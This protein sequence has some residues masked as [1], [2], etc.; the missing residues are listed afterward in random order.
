MA[1]NETNLGNPTNLGELV[2]SKDSGSPPALGGD[3]VATNGFCGAETRVSTNIC[4][5]LHPAAC[6][7]P[8]GNIG[9]AWHDT[10]DGNFEIYFRAM[11]GNLDDQRLSLAQGFAFDPTTG[12]PVSLSCTALSQP[13]G[14]TTASNILVTQGGGRL[15]VNTI[16]RVAV[17]TASNGSI[18]FQSIGVTP[19]SSVQF[20]NG[21]NVGKT[22]YVSRLLAPTVAE[23]NYVDGAKADSDFVYSISKAEAKLSTK[24]ARLTC[25]RGNSQ[26]PDI[27]AD[28]QGRFHIVYQDSANGNYELYYIQVY[29]QEIGK[30]NCVG[31]SAPV[32]VVGF[33]EV[34]PGDPNSVTVY[35][36]S[37]VATT[38][39][40]VAPTKV[41]YSKTGDTGTLFTFGNKLLSDAVPISEGPVEN[42]T[43]FHKIFRDFY[44][45]HGEW[46]GISLAEDRAVWDLQAENAAITTVPDFIGQTGHPIAGVDD[47]GTRLSIENLAFI[48]QSPP[49]KDVEITRIG[50]PLKPRCL[51]DSA[52]NAKTPNTASLISAPK[53]PVPPGYSDA[54]SLAEILTSPLAQIDDSVPPRF[55]VEGDT[56]GTVFTN[57]L[58]DDGRGQFSRFVFNCDERHQ[59]KEPRFIL[60]QR[61]CGSELCA[62]DPTNTSEITDTSKTAEYKIKLQ[63]WEGPDYRITPDQILS[64]QFANATKLIEKEFGFE[65]GEDITSFDF[66]AGELKAIDGR[67]LFF[68]P[69]PADGAEF[70]VE[71]VGGGHAVWSTD[72]L[73]TFDQYY[74]PFTVKPNA[75]L[76]APVYYEGILKDA[77]S[78]ATSSA[79]SK[80]GAGGLADGS[81]FAIDVFTNNFNS[82]WNGFI[83]FGAHE[84]GVNGA[85][86]DRFDIAS[87][88]KIE[89]AMTA[90]TLRVP[91]AI[92]NTFANQ[93]TVNQEVVNIKITGVTADG[94]PD[95][96][97]VLFSSVFP[98]TVLPQ[99]PPQPDDLQFG[100]ELLIDIPINTALPV[101]TY[102]I[103]IQ[104]RNNSSVVVNNSSIVDYRTS[105]AQ[106]ENVSPTN[107][108]MTAY[109]VSG[110]RKNL[111]ANVWSSYS[112]FTFILT[113]EGKA[114]SAATTNSNGDTQV[115]PTGTSLVPT[116]L[117]TATVLANTVALKFPNKTALP[118][119]STDSIG[120]NFHIFQSNNNAQKQIGVCIGSGADLNFN[121]N[122]LA[123]GV[124]SFQVIRNRVTTVLSTGTT[125]EVPEAASTIQSVVISTSS[126]STG[127]STTTTG[128]PGDLISTPPIRLTKS[129]GDSV[130]PRLAIDS[131]D[132]IWMVY[133][134][135]RTGQNEV[136]LGRYFCGKWATSAN[137]G[138][139]VRLTNASDNGKSA[140]FPNIALDELGN[141]H[142]VY[143]SDDTTDEVSEIFYTRSTGG[144]VSFVTPKQLTASPGQA[145]MPDICISD[146]ATSS[147]DS[148]GQGTGRTTV[149]WHDNRFGSYEIMAAVKT[150]GEWE[151]SGQGG[152]DTRI[153]Q[154]RGD[155][156]FPRA[157]SDH[158]GNVRVVYHDRRRGIDN[159]CVYMSTFIAKEN[160][161]DSTA[162]GGIDLLVSVGNVSDESLHP[163]VAIDLVDGVYVAWHDTR[164][165]TEQD[166]KEEVMGAYCARSNAPLGFCGP[167]LT[168][169]EAFVQTSFDIVDPVNGFPIT[170]T[171]IP[172]VGLQIT[173]PGATFYRISNE[174]QP[175]SEWTTFKPTT[176]L[177][178]S[179]IPWDLGSGSGKK[180]ICIQVQDATT[181]GF[182]ICKEIVLQASLPSFKVE[183]FKDKEFM[184]PLET[185]NNKPVSPSGDIYVRLTSST[186]LIRPPTFDIISKGT[187]M[188]FNQETR[189]VSGF[190]GFSGGIGPAVIGDIVA[191]TTAFSAFGGT[192]FEGRF[193]VHRD[194]GLYYLDGPARLIPHGKDIRGQVF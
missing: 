153:T 9:V 172:Q 72:G 54:V 164:F 76:D 20:I 115:V 78:G 116:F 130:H 119:N 105:I 60:G 58:I 91:I 32:N 81:N 48:A 118:D 167:I 192:T 129:K 126:T 148:N 123:D 8:D 146:R 166:V 101:G 21:L 33:S 155:S 102:A 74:V 149:V 89:N 165:R 185:F 92:A 132:N 10:R 193:T 169:V 12:K 154:A 39:T 141:A 30:P 142:V 93:D 84:S 187:R 110:A 188:I 64:S 37:T 42:R 139:D 171:N 53:K 145:Q 22:F 17:L 51:P 7:T 57:V 28:S 11:Q 176:G 173:S 26:F 179:I 122:S 103:V 31:A 40:V 62:L 34:L 87:I 156:L 134:S 77:S 124:Y 3:K 80:G 67:F 90:K 94:L 191:G 100:A 95:D 75:G 177:D 144:G 186:P 194:D 106:S 152:A 107:T 182:P 5:S 86:L 159:P 69:I 98:E 59:E 46:V 61:R 162:Q 29:P 133:H 158:E 125:T 63:V 50:L 88:F 97:V 163:D 82:L 181:V 127:G 52:A 160:S 178:T 136:Y 65:P 117:L 79:S 121:V 184:I 16:S 104:P 49:D 175:Y 112:P 43:G 150:N 138:N 137:G 140:Q 6:F 71:A 151:S 143:Q 38:S 111:A 66:K 70:F 174:G 55:T 96:S 99:Q 14:S 180:K 36:Q 44:T 157:A 18:N 190:S 1:N 24:E 128:S 13:A 47:F 25:N 4:N 85:S 131:K 147:D 41:T 19:N 73:G 35:V 2:I 56:S 135:N 120:Y 109:S 68:V 113:G 161:W 183:F 114:N 83:A 170:S 15:D 168:N 189:L 108:E 23:L 27:V 45:G